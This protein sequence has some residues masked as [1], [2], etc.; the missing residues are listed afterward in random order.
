LQVN[1]MQ[2]ARLLNAAAAVLAEEGYWGMS[3]A[4][5]TRRA[6][7]SRRTFYDV[8]EGREDCFLAAFDRA[9]ERVEGLVV[10]AFEGAGAAGGWRGRV[11][12]GL[13]ALLVFLD[14]ERGLGSLLVVDA[15]T[16]GPVVLQRRAEVLG[17]I[18]AALDRTGNGLNGARELSELTGEGVVGAVFSVIHT[19]ITGEDA[20]SLVGLLNPLMGVIVLPYLGSGAAQ[21]ELERPAPAYVRGTNANGV[22]RSGRDVRVHGKSSSGASAGS[23]EQVRDPLA[24]L[25]MRMTYRTMCV[26]AV[27]NER[28]GL[29]NRVI[30]ESAGASDQ[31][32]ISKLLQ[33]LEKLGLIENT[34]AHAHQ[35]TGEP[36]AWRLTVLGEEVEQATR[37]DPATGRG[38][39]RS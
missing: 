31:G 22:L 16:A 36:N 33:R 9:V 29:S 6:R 12:A 21:K 5:V 17:R 34:T 37:I 18:G 3:V 25:P 14:E 26:L 11:R 32:Q 1:E 15:L 19:R 4:R 24:D 39:E 13:L 27:I 30:G 8:F 2:R 20:G 28:P 35:P 23:R 10:E 38:G 7:V